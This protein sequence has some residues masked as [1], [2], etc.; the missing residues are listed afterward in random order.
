MSE[1]KKIRKIKVRG[2]QHRYTDFF[3][4]S[5]RSVTK[6]KNR[7]KL[8]HSH[9]FKLIHKH[10]TTRL[11]WYRRWFGWKHH[12]LVDYSLS[13]LTLIG[14]TIMI[15]LS[16][17]ARASGS[18]WTQSDWS[19]GV[20]SSTSNQYVSETNSTT[21]TANQFTLT[22]GSN[23]FTSGSLSTTASLDSFLGVAP[24][25]ISGLVQWVNASNGV[26][27]DLGV[28][29]ATN[30]Q[31]VEEWADMSG[32]GNTYSQTISSKRPTLETNTLNGWPVLHHTAANSDDL[33]SPLDLVGD[34][35]TIMYVA[36]QTG[37]TRQ[38]V[39]SAYGN[40][41]LL[42]WW[43]GLYDQAYFNGWVYQPSES[44]IST[45]AYEFTGT[46]NGST[47]YE[48]D[49]G[50]Q[51]GSANSTSFTGP[52][53]LETVGIG[54]SGEMSDAN[55]AEIIAYNNVL[56]TANRQAL[57]NYLDNKYAL[58]GRTDTTSSSVQYNGNNSTKI[59]A[60]SNSAQV[61]QA[62][63]TGNTEP[64]ILTAYA[65]VGPSTPVTSSNAQLYVNGATVGTT[66]T[67]VGND[68][69]QLQATVTG[70]NSSVYYGVQVASGQT[71]YLSNLSLVNYP[72]S[73]SLTSNIFNTG[74]G[75]NWGN[76]SYSATVPSGSTVTVLVRAGSQPNLSDAPAF[77]SCS[78]ISSGSA[79]T[80]SCAPSKAQYVQYEVMFTS[81]GGVTPTFT[82]ITIP[83]TPSD[84]TPPATNA[85]NINATDGNGGS[86]VASLGWINTD[87][88]FSWTAAT[89]HVGGSGIA[90]YCI[91]LGQS[92]SGNPITS[93]GDLSTSSPLNT[94]GACPFAVSTSNI[95]TSINSY[96]T[97][98]LS[99]STSPYYL[100]IDAI[101]GAGVVW[102]GSPAQFE[103][104]F[105]NT[106]P[107]NPAFIT[108][109]SE[110]VSSDEVTLTWATSGID[111]AS[112]SISGV[113]GLQ[114]KIGSSGTWY[115]VLHN[116]NQDMSDLL[117]NS[118]AYTTISTPDFANLVQ[119][120][121]IVYFRTWNN[122]GVVS[123]AYVTTVIKLNS[124]APSSL[125]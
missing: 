11:S 122:A 115:G 78:A 90:G 8:V 98:A 110:F 1:T 51:V 29:N 102:N 54:G 56:S 61:V 119:G 6:L 44:A 62:V 97:T 108:A 92:S 117:S 88:Y 17:F 72:T 46:Y 111:A 93:S 63:N 2:S 12:K 82:S 48:Y 109:P 13:G 10:L 28:T 30:G 43:S 22:Q 26:Y 67:S 55:L 59:V 68:W 91:Y 35:F 20:G 38:R 116:G 40:N 19:G 39:L 121:N 25:N 60:G 107:T 45:N 52:N 113:A 96:I 42:G 114:Y 123:A 83:Y 14:L 118:G 58:G 125:S 84:T 23:Q 89:D 65:Y 4:S 27:T 34:N 112:D 16:Q 76:L 101:T 18:N 5:I 104:Y 81:N 100:N 31:T 99:S 21:S 77:T 24:S 9:S 32:Q 75:E 74:V 49:D 41:W 95:D 36:S 73:G 53:E 79:I 86:S 94:G 85:T 105:D 3:K 70:S 50:N 7:L 66:Y 37:P 15:S 106:P 71:L 57:D 124:T 47:A 33:V 69:Y 64:T 80:S 103:F 120:N 87:P